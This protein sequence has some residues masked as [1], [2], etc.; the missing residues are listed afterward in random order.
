MDQSNLLKELIEFNDG[1]RPR[2]PEGKY[3]KRNIYESACALYEDWE[4]ILNAFKTQIF[5]IKETQGK[6]WKI[7]T[8]KQML[9]RL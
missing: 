2:T 4:L 9:Q 5:P 1:P 8:S 3:K 6:G 7:L